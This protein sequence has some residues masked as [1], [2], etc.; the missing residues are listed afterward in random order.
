MPTVKIDRIRVEDRHRQDLGDLSSL[1]KSI[2]DIGLLHPIVITDDFRL[3]AGQRR[4]E[5]CRK[6]GWSEVPTTVIGD[7]ESA[8]GLL[9]AERDEN[10]CRKAM[11]AS[12][13]YALGKELEALKRPDNAANQAH[14]QTA[15][16]R[17]ASGGI[18]RSDDHNYTREFVGAGLDM[19]GRTWQN[20]KHI[21]DRAAEGD[22]EA[23]EVLA[24]IDRGDQG[25]WAG[26]EQLR[27]K[28]DKARSDAQKDVQKSD[29]NLGNVGDL[30]SIPKRRSATKQLRNLVK[31]VDSLGYAASRVDVG[32]VTKEEA[33]AIIDG[34]SDGLSNLTAL[35]NRLRKATK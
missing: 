35:R 4:L 28:P 20:L 31:Q 17:N 21:G 19:S 12:E 15:P 22:E 3:I 29:E 7:I 14:G 10:T 25:I 24:S 33:V 32:E 18:S 1:V 30:R 6:L 13:L 5:A 23:Q 27:G 9:V 26:Y 8:A 34:L 11:R 16:G 2:E